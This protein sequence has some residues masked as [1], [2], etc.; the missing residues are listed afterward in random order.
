VVRLLL[1]AGADI[2]ARDADGETALFTLD[3]DAVR[4]LLAR[5][6]DIHI[7]NAAGATALMAA[8]SDSITRMLV[9][10]GAQV[11]ATNAQGRTAL[12]LAAADGDLA[13]VQVLLKARADSARK[14]RAGRTA[15]ELAGEGLAHALQGLKQEAYR[16]IAAL[17]QAAENRADAARKGR[18]G[19]S[20]P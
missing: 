4:E 17:L 16:K 15:L 14:D 1:D 10:A 20:V 9:G 13:K 8:T 5:K 11:D 3:E 19:G 7:R 18:A 12:M 6:I 2:S